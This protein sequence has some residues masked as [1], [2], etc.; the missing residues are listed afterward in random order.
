MRILLLS[1]LLLLSC[2]LMA[3][4]VGGASRTN[5]GTSNAE[6][7]QEDTAAPRTYT[8]TTYSSRYKFDKGVQSRGVQTKPVEVS[9]NAQ[10]ELP[11]AV[12]EE[13]T[14]NIAVNK[15]QAKN[16]PPP[17][18]KPAP[19]AAATQTASQQEA[20][21]EI[22]PEASAAMAQLGQMQGMLQ[23]LQNMMGGAGGNAQGNANAGAMPAGMPDLSALMGGKA[24]VKK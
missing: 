2:P 4:N 14:V 10:N 23:G 13:P 5:F 18:G 3:F 19:A 17:A 20:S 22:P 15:K 9:G 8:A 12:V 16:V 1:F 21:M 24:P 11:P 6:A 7:N